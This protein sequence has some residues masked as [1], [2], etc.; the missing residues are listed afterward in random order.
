[1]TTSEVTRILSRI[2]SG[3]PQAANQLLP[4]VYEELRK[5]AAARMQAERPDH[6]LQPTALVHEAYLRLIESPQSWE[7]RG[8]FFAAAA[9]SMRQILVNWAVAR[10]TAKR[11]GQ[12]R[13]VAIADSLAEPGMDPDLILDLDAALTELAAEDNEAA[14]LVKLRLLAGLSVTEAGQILSLSRSNAYETWTFA[15]AWFA[16]RKRRTAENF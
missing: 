7:T 11:G 10:R 13:S 9:R 14:E 12:V 16:E 4:Y 2:E 8:H 1:V 15:R 3:D 5:L 6:T